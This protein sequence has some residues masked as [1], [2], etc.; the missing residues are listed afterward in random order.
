MFR[1]TQYLRE[2]AQA[3]RSGEFPAAR[4]RTGAAPILTPTASDH[5]PEAPARR[6][7]PSPAPAPLDRKSTRLNSSHS[8]QSRMPSSA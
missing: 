1:V 3:E 6:A 8:Q 4:R 7:A 2:L 5:G